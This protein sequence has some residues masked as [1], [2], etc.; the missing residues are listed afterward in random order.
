MNN[1]FAYIHQSINTK[2]KTLNEMREMILALGWPFIN[3]QA[4]SS[5]RLRLQDI[6]ATP[7]VIIIF[8]LDHQLADAKTNILNC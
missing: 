5:D 8:I 6:V 3:I 4:V 1:L 7:T 2:P